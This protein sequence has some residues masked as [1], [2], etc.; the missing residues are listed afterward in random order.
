MHKIPASYYLRKA[1]KS[2]TID[3]VVTNYSHFWNQMF[4]QTNWTL[5]KYNDAWEKFFKNIMPS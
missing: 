1:A 3:D 4:R 2:D 5:T